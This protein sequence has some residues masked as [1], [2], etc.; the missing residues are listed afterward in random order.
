M[1]E[2][3]K[4]KSLSRLV[5]G[6]SLGGSCESVAPSAGPQDPVAAFGR[7]P[8]G[9][10]WVALQMGGPANGWPLDG[11]GWPR[12]HWPSK[13]LKTYPNGIFMKQN[14]PKMRNGWPCK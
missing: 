12:D 14:V 5:A 13:S 1:G 6:L 7:Q 8:R 4:N 11:N 3:K 9:Q 10:Q 2:E